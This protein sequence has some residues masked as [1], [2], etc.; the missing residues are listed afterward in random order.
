MTDVNG[1]LIRQ[2]FAMKGKMSFFG[3]TAAVD[4]DVTR[5]RLVLDGHLSPV[6]L[7]KNSNLFS[8]LVSPNEQPPPPAGSGASIHVSTDD[9]SNPLQ[10]S[11]RCTFLTISNNLYI[12]LSSS[13]LVFAFTHSSADIT[14]FSVKGTI[15]TTSISITSSL[16]FDFSFTL[17]VVIENVNLGSVCYDINLNADANVDFN[18]L[19]ET[20]GLYI[21]GTYDASLNNN[22]F[23]ANVNL[24]PFDENFSDIESLCKQII[25]LIKSSINT[26]LA[27]VL[28]SLTPTDAVSLLVAFGFT[29]LDIALVLILLGFKPSDVLEVIKTIGKLSW[30]QIASIAFMVGLTADEAIDVMRGMGCGTWDLV[31]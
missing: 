13:G 18:W 1:K 31:W 3:L 17:D 16:E 19:A 6:I 23:S 25:V 29:F 30:D 10:I 15:S 12:D 5:T 7:L 27:T 26:D 9:S 4:I 22:H 11:C 24:G 20:W 21:S 2:E 28:P 14:S 8:I